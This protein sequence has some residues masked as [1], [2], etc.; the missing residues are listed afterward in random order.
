MNS[1][2]QFALADSD[3][4]QTGV[5]QRGAGLVARLLIEGQCLLKQGGGL[6]VIAPAAQRTPG[7]QGQRMSNATLVAKLSHDVGSLLEQPLG[8]VVIAKGKFHVAE[9]NQGTGN[10]ALIATLM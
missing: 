3:L 5:D 4:A 8:P 9:S 7:K 1:L 10:A 2:L 6:R